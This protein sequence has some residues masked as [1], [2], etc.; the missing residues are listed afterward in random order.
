MLEAPE[1]VKPQGARHVLS[2]V[3]VGM[4]VEGGGG[5]REREGER[6]RQEAHP[7][8]KELVREWGR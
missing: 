3:S 2:P 8:H 4:R 1:G 5:E 6:E 7:S